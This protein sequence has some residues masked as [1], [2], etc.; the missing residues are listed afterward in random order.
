MCRGVSAA[1][2]WRR[3]AARALAARWARRDDHSLRALTRIVAEDAGTQMDWLTTVLKTDQPLAELVR[4]Y[5]DLLLSL[6]PSPTKIVTA[7]F[8]MCQTAEE[9]ITMLMDLKTDFDE[10]ID[11]M[12]NVIEAPRPNKDEVPLSALRELGRAAGAPLRALLPKYTDLQTT[13]FLSYLE[14]PQVKQEDLLEQSRALL[15]VAERSEGWLSAARGRGERIAGV[16]VHPFYDPSVEAFTSA[17]LNLI[18]SHTRRIESQFLSSVSAGRSAGVLS[19]S[20][21][22]ALVLEHATAVLLDTLAGQRAWGEEPKPDNPLLDLK[23]I[24]LDAEMRQVPRTSPPSVA[25]LRR[26]RDVL[27]TL[28]R[29]IL[30]NPI[31]VQLG[32]F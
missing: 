24:L 6:D 28:A 13:L 7:N 18:T 10:F 17:V 19:D 5:T 16:A 8:K 2:C 14:E 4:L 27:K 23:T 12:R 11:C 30:R 21:P 9:G 3:A 20:F 31:D 15:A 22:A 25:G 29:S 26:A 1:R 32:K